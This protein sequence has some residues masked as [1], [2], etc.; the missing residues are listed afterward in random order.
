MR[1][2]L[3]YHTLERCYEGVTH[4]QKR[5]D[6]AR[7]LECVMAKLCTMRSI[8]VKWAPFNPEVAAALKGKPLRSVPNEAAV[9]DDLL[10]EMRLQPEALELPPPRLFV[11]ERA[12]KLRKRDQLISDYMVLKLGV[13][14]VLVELEPPRAES[15]AP[16]LPQ[17]APPDAVEMILRMERGRQGAQRVAALRQERAAQA[18][19]LAEAR[20]AAERAKAVYDQ[21]FE[22]AGGREGGGAGDGSDG[23]EEDP[24]QAAAHAAAKAAVAAHAAATA[25]KRVKHAPTGEDGEDPDDLLTPAEAATAIQRIVRGFTARRRAARERAHELRFLGMRD[26]PR[27][28]LKGLELALGGVVASRLRTQAEHKEGLARALPE[29]HKLVL[30]SEGPETRDKL[31]AER[32]AWFTS[33]LAIGE[34]PED[35]QG[36][37]AAQAAAAGGG[38]GDAEAEA[39]AKAEAEAK[40]KAAAGKDAGKDKGKGKGGPPE[41]EPEKPPQLLGPSAWSKQVAALVAEYRDKWDGRDERDNPAQRYDEELARVVV[42]PAVAEELRLEVDAVLADQLANFKASQADKKKDKKSEVPTPDP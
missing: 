41:P 39:K 23:G 12:E 8:V 29:V 35:L 32:L 38:G 5:Q 30:E 14:R 24:V 9:F 40:A 13:E 15:E 19:A 7:L 34:V 25:P 17:L 3:A 21:A 16:T 10:A 28:A 2:L 42:R 18:K 31:K 11:D 37:Y 20:A 1:Y 36:F 26:G 4:P 6:I 22:A 27:P 33:Q